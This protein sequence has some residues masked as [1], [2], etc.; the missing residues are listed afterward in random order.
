MQD[1]NSDLVPDSQLIQDSIKGCPKRQHELYHRFAS[2]MFLVCLRYTHNNTA[3][4]EDILQEG[5]VKVFRNLH[6]F[7]N[8]GSFEGW[9]R[10]IVTR[11]ALSHLRDKNKKLV[12]YDTERL[13]IIKDNET[14]ILDRL[15]EKDMIR[16]VSKLPPGYRK[17][18]MLYVIDGY[19]HREIASM[20]NCNE[21]TSKSQLYRSKNKLQELYKKT[22]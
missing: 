14:S 11:T 9:I 16:M 21:G 17:I 15:A 19:N 5:F 6:K 12:N 8:D 1:F 22:A 7:R 10:T 13:H 20:L 4:A 18:F 3:D 2:K